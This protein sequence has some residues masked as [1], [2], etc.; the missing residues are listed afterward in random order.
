VLHPLTLVFP[1]N[2]CS[3]ATDLCVSWKG[4]FALDVKWINVEVGP[5]LP[6]KT[7]VGCVYDAPALQAQV[8]YQPGQEPYLIK[9]DYRRGS[10]TVQ[11][12]AGP[13][14]ED[15]TLTPWKLRMQ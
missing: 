15:E 8:Y 4:C 7:V 13:F 1:A 14:S 2:D 3:Q 9:A 10:G 6:E 5:E 11:I 12:E